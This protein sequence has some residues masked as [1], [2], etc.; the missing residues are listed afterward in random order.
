[1]EVGNQGSLRIEY[2][3]VAAAEYRGADPPSDRLRC[4]AIGFWIFLLSDIVIEQA[5]LIR[6]NLGEG[7]RAGPT[8]APP[9]ACCLT[10][11]C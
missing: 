11:S 4:T 9:T 6:G 8:V 7:T 3:T 1:M 10:S 2:A 5:D